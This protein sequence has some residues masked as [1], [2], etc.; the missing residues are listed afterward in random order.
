MRHRGIEPRISTSP[1]RRSNVSS[2]ETC[3]APSNLCLWGLHR[4][5]Y[6]FTDK[7]VRSTLFDAW[8][9][10][11]TSTYGNWKSISQY[12]GLSHRQ[13][14]IDVCIGLYTVV[15]Y[16][17]Y[18]GCFYNG[19]RSTQSPRAVRWLL[20]AFRYG[21]KG[22]PNGKYLTLNADGRI[23]THR[24]CFPWH[25]SFQDCALITIW[26]RRRNGN[27]LR[28]ACLFRNQPI[29]FTIPIT[30]IAGFEPTTS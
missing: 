15:P 11:D 28:K 30:Q 12:Y 5:L 29:G 14:H 7:F 3:A 24:P 1:W 22:V 27:A 10:P 16:H 8:F 2:I 21:V 26:V 13:S 4:I 17:T 9:N 23:W 19:G 6:V 25:I 20:T 18:T